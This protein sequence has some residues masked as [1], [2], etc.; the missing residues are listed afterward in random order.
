MSRYQGP[1]KRGT[2]N[3]VS[4]GIPQLS[5]YLYQIIKGDSSQRS[6]SLTLPS[7]LR[8]EGE[9]Q[10]FSLYSFILRHRVERDMPRC[11]AASVWLPF[12][13]ARV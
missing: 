6:S 2:D 4:L 1:G 11:F 7:P 8:G 10:S 13:R 5:K 9:N 12:T 3:F